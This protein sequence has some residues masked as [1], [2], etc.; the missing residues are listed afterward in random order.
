M[1]T[2][3]LDQ[4]TDTNG[5]AL[6]S[7]TISPTNTPA[8]SWVVHT[9]S[10]D[11]QSNRA[12]SANTTTGHATVDSGAANVTITSIIN[13]VGGGS[14]IYVTFRFTDVDNKWFLYIVPTSAWSLYKRV[15]GTNT[16]V[17]SGIAPGVGDRTITVVCNGNSI[18]C[19]WDATNELATTDSFNATATKHGIMYDTSTG[20]RWDNFQVDE[21]AS[22]SIDRA[23]VLANSGGTV[24][25]SL[26]GTATSWT[27]GTTL[28]LTVGPTGWSKASQ[29]I[30]DATHATITLNR[31]SGTG[32]LTI[33]DGTV[34]ANTTASLTGT[35]TATGN[36]STTTIWDALEAPGNGNRA[37]I[38]HDVTITSAV[39]IGDSPLAGNTV[40]T[41]NASKTLTVN[42]TRSLAVRGDVAQA[43]N[44][45]V[46]EASGGATF[47]FDASAASP[48][49]QKYKITQS[50]AG[51]N[52]R[53]RGTAGSRSVFRS[54]S[55]GSNGYIPPA[56][57]SGLWDW[58]FC[59][60]LRIGDGTNDLLNTNNGNDPGSPTI[61]LDVQD[62]TFTSC[63]RIVAGQ[64]F[65]TNAGWRFLRNNF[66]SSQH[67]TDSLRLNGSAPGGS[68]VR[69][70]GNS[71]STGNSFDKQLY[72]GEASMT[73]I[74]GNVFYRS[75]DNPGSGTW[76]DSIMS[77]NLFRGTNASS[78]MAVRG[79]VTDCYI[80]A[81]G[82]DDNPHVMLPAS[83]GAK[84]VD[85]CVVEF[86]GTI[87]TDAGN[88]FYGGGT[89]TVQRCIVLKIMALDHPAGSVTFNAPTCNLY[90]N[91]LY[92]PDYNGGIL[93]GDGG[94]TTGTYAN[95]KSNLFWVDSNVVGA[96]AAHTIGVQADNT[97]TPANCTHNGLVNMVTPAYQGSY[98]TTQ[99]G[100][101]D[102]RINSVDA[103]AIF[104]DKSR[105]IATWAV[106]RG[107][108]S[109][110]YAGKV[111]DALT[112][113]RADPTLVPNLLAHV[114][115]GF[116]PVYAPFRN[117][118][119]DGVTIG[120]VEMGNGPGL[121]SSSFRF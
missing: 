81:D 103:G 108:V 95:V 72:F 10:F 104:T 20:N 62:C 116:A 51:S 48:T 105:N 15:A 50:A 120:A 9:G 79:N 45:Y 46:G 68:V 101:N 89:W 119:H 90:H 75:V 43:G 2:L 115:A 113:L 13:G 33:S 36:W 73:A 97:I 88:W 99:P 82:F 65:P 77:D 87:L 24:T 107:S 57:S 22:I 3:L 61:W 5:T 70:I 41:I 23:T 78:T 37:V 59:D 35:T 31:G 94:S 49:T 29:V 52:L 92:S 74:K 96:T 32:T 85:G 56:I 47:E 69:E 102:V 27:G 63:G 39:T 71:S 11:I 76:G 4:F 86:T 109:G 121:L 40:L 60:F 12:N 117:A 84:T 25:L 66:S 106:T 1:A 112:Y 19:K 26:T 93:I 21:I 18:S 91:T 55:G 67:S 30:T 118:G 100:A 80:L 34:S 6:A 98:P 64:S 54:N 7:H 16:L 17:Q 53:I 111:A 58:Q 38:A 28:S 8:V 114:R 44:L 14:G 110:T 42:A 83:V